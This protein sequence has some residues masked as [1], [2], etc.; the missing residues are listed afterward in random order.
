MS[1]YDIGDELYFEGRY[2]EAADVFKECIL[3]E[4]ELNS[5]MNYLGCCELNLGNFDQALYWF[6][7]IIERDPSWETPYISKG[8]VLMKL[9][10][11]DEAKKHLDKALEINGNN[12]DI[13]YYIGVYYEQQGN[14]HEAETAYFNSL[15][16]APEQSETLLNYGVV[17]NKLENNIKAEEIFKRVLHLD[18]TEINAIW[19]LAQINI[20]RGHY[21]DAINYLNRYIEIHENDEEVTD[22]INKLKQKLKLV[23]EVLI[24]Y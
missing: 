9:G 7:Q 11:F 18:P 13:Y 14:L 23:H 3:Q 5:S 4:I 15:A 8:R 2:T 19:N 10:K 24:P 17:I 12:E 1:L 21:A 22:L 20:G 6:E 16:I